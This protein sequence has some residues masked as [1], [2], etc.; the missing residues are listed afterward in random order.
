M[1][2]KLLIIFK[3]ISITLNVQII[4]LTLFRSSLSSEITYFISPQIQNCTITVCTG[5][6][7]KPFDNILSALQSNN[8]DVNYTI[9][10]IPDPT[11]PHYLLVTEN[12]TNISNYYDYS[13]SKYI[14]NGLTIKPLFCNEYPGELSCIKD[15]ETVTIYLKSE[16]FTI[17]AYNYINLTNVIWIAAKTLNFGILEVIVII[18]LYAQQL[19]S[20][21]AKLHYQIHQ[22]C[23]MM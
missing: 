20:D 18:C 17:I 2:N 21:V 14:I 6:I 7:S 10:L 19:E 1:Y 3:Y 15:D 9:I 22:E 8:S 16:F 13:N 12:F 4:L 5:D 11:Y 23:I